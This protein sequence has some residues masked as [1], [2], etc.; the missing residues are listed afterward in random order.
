MTIGDDDPRVYQAL[1]LPNEAIA[2]GGNEILRVGVIDGDLLVSAR[3]A[4]QHPSK[5]GEVLADV[6]GRLAALYAAGAERLNKKDVRIQIA[7][8]F[9]A[10]M[11]ARPVTTR[12]PN[13]SKTRTMTR[14]TRHTAKSKPASKKTASKKTAARRAAKPAVRRKKR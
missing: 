8:A 2:N 6:A 1:A 5:W 14:T 7:E 10:E 12:T 11:G 13:N 9:V 4:F 3:T